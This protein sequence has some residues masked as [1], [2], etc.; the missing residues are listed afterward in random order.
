M[1]KHHVDLRPETDADAE[2]LFSLYAS[3]REQELGAVPWSAEQRDA[4]LKG[5]F[6]AQTLHY[7]TQY[8]DAAFDIVVIDHRP[9][10]R[11]YHWHGDTEI[12]IIDITLAPQYRAQGI[13]STLLK[14]FLQQA[15]DA[16][17]PV[18]IH[19][20]RNNPA[21]R[22]YERLGFSVIEDK[23]VYLLLERKVYSRLV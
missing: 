3:T 8:P 17:L 21:L 14:N 23:G 2:F 20:E 18:T 11:L 19:V 6:R 9:G 16:A 15:D 1:P 7:R 5:Q 22:L 4:F 10:G 12:R 13:G